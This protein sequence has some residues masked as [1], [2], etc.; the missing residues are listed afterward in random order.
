M[1]LTFHGHPLSS[2]CWK[3]LIALYENARPFEFALVDL[4]DLEAAARFRKLSPMGMMPVLQDA[5]ADLT[6]C[7]TSIILEY[8]DQKHPGPVRLLPDDADQAREVRYWDRFYDLYVQGPM[9]RIVFDRLRPAGKRD[10]F[11]VEH[12]LQQLRTAY[13]VAERTMAGR[14][15]AAGETFSMADCAAAPALYY[16][17]KVLSFTGSHPALAAYSR[18]LQA[19]PSFAR[20]LKEAEPYAHMFPQEPAP[21]PV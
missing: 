21:E 5:A 12:A 2:F 9:Q 4:G 15:W 7:E 14:A 13:D 1:S 10:A 3:V 6:I 20:V 16:G 17:E 11:G 8:L 19:R 18:R